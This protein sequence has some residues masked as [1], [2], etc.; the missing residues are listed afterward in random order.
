MLLSIT[1]DF[2]CVLKSAVFLFNYLK[3]SIN[4]GLY[5]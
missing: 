5:P 3:T 1:A 2:K 4:P